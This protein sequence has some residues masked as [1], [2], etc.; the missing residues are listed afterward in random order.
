MP[1][2]VDYTSTQASGPDQWQSHLIRRICAKF[3]EARA[4]LDRQAY[5]PGGVAGLVDDAAG[6]FDALA[7]TIPRPII[8]NAT[9][10][11][12]PP[13]TPVD[14]DAPQERE[15]PLPRWLTYGDA[16]VRHE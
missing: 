9:A 11:V 13:L 2:P 14:T 1:N 12:R 3:L 10:S 4:V 6:F 7:V 5:I 8:V 15:E 16:G